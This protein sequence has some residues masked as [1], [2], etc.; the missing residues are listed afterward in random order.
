MKFTIILYFILLNSFAVAEDRAGL[1]IIKV[2][3][4]L[5]NWKFFDAAS[6]Y[7]CGVEERLALTPTGEV[8]VLR[9]L[10]LS[11]NVLKS[12]FA[13]IVDIDSKRDKL[14]LCRKFI[15]LVSPSTSPALEIYPNQASSEIISQQLTDVSKSHEV[16]KEAVDR[17]RMVSSALGNK[18]KTASNESL[19]IIGMLEGKKII[20]YS[21]F[22]SKAGDELVNLTIEKID[23]L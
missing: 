8:C 20:C 10:P 15:S 18:E 2:E 17:V 14:F 16:I 7:E 11:I 12:L 4:G 6:S 1:S 22:L 5:K 13:A 19:V 3:R 21:L 23:Q 9:D